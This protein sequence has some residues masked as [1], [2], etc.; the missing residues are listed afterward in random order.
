MKSIRPQFILSVLILC[1]SLSSI[2]ATRYVTVS[3][4]GSLDGSSWA[5]AAPGSALQFMVNTA[6]PGDEIW[7]AC[8]TYVPTT[9]NNR[10]ISF[11]M[12]NGISIYGGFAGTEATLEEREF[13]CGTC[14]IL[15]G[16]IGAAGITDNSFKIVSNEELNNTAILDGFEIRDANDNR[17]PSNAGNGLGGGLYN[18]GFGSTGFCN[19]VIRN[20]FFTNNR[21]SWGAGAFNNGYAGGNAE[22]TYI[23]C[24][25]YQNH[26]YI[27]AGG[28]DSYGVGG[29]ASPTL[30]NCI[31][32]SNTSASNV[33]AM[34][35]WGG[36]VGGNCHPV[37]I[38]CIFT[39]NSALNGYAGAFI[40][41]NLNEVGGGSSG[42]CTVT[43]QNCIVRNNTA[44]GAGP[45][46]CVRGNANA[47]VLATY[48]NIDLSGQ[49]GM[50]VLSGSTIGNID[51]DPLF[52]DI[53]N[54][55]G[56]DFCWL[57]MDDGLRMTNSSPSVN[58]G[59]N[60]G[61]HTEDITGESRI[62][63]GTVDMG[64]YENQSP[65]SAALLS[66][67]A[68]PFDKT[69]KINWTTTIEG[70]T[71]SYTI[72]KSMNGISWKEL[73]TISAART[74]SELEEYYVWDYNPY[75]GRT[76]YRLLQKDSDGQ[77][78]YSV[79]KSVITK[80]D[81]RVQIY[82][83][84]VADKLNIIFNDSDLH[85][86][87]ILDLFGI[88]QYSGTADLDIKIDLNSL[89]NGLYLL[90]IDREMVRKIIKE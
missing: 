62:N 8:G 13:I 56:D 70:N 37:L 10:S 6:A 24:I 15:S 58:S 68:L 89:S 17:A 81:I 51:S 11:S 59:S 85:Q 35:A 2:A 19:P 27:E 90:R 66:F 65:L 32:D 80:E 45:Q 57:T 25:F 46:F 87:E 72:Q 28:M 12:R 75:P 21:A 52:L 33:G 20:C 71:E 61:V 41:D 16:E 39:N 55:A 36:N 43:L 60:T 3:G 44:T 22:P 77:Q 49:N 29:N 86:I 67:E 42:S 79:V 83:N 48:S 88:I 30:Y 50:H 38:N 53:S 84:P 69:V 23:N 78:K 40:A 31:F 7:V 4:A 9:D 64:P 1:F 76:Y 47:Q 34:Y 54:A 74:G 5:N 73:E 82:P 63:A 18:H 26:A 14:S